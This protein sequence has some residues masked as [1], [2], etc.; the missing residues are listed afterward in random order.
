MR[1][2]LFISLFCLSLLAQTVLASKIQDNIYKLPHSKNKH[3]GPSFESWLH[4]DTVKN[5][6]SILVVPDILWLKEESRA[7]AKSFKAL[8]LEEKLPNALDAE[9][10]DEEGYL[11]CRSLGRFEGATDDSFYTTFT[12]NELSRF[13]H[14]K[15]H[16]RAVIFDFDP[17]CFSQYQNKYLEI[18]Y[19][20]NSKNADRT[21]YRFSRLVFSED[22][23][24]SVAK[25]DF[26]LH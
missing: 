23:K 10:A 16:R 18:R 19:Y 20:P 6:V 24:Q 14:Y 2:T 4:I 12:K 7:S 21:A 1:K 5:A 8:P 17:R 15:D 3:G 22:I 26:R 11:I 25:A 13:P 9:I